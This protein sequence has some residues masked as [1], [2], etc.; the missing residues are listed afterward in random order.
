MKAMAALEMI[1]IMIILLVVAG[2]V[3]R[4]FMSTVSTGVLPKFDP[5]EE[6]K[7][8]IERVCSP[9]CTD[10]AGGSESAGI[11]FC[12]KQF[13]DKDMTGD[14]DYNDPFNPGAAAGIVACENSIYCPHIYTC[15]LSGGGV[16]GLIECKQLLCDSMKRTYLSIGLDDEEAS[17]KASTEILGLIKPGNCITPS[18]KIHWYNEIYGKAKPICT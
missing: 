4:M 13:V 6:R 9:L 3:I 5:V 15:K 14:N 12:K 18:G 11:E 17:E 7:K 8:E 16:L 2:V 1:V 10:Y